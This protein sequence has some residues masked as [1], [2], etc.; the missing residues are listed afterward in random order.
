MSEARDVTAGQI[1]LSLGAAVSEPAPDNGARDGRFLA[2][3]PRVRLQ[4]WQ[5]RLAGHFGRLAGTR[6]DS[7]WPVF[8][9]E[10][11]LH[12]SDRDTLMRDVREC[13]VIGPTRDVPLPWIVYAVEIGYDYSGFEYWQTFESKTPGWQQEWRG[14]IRSRFTAF[15]ATYHGAEPHGDWADQFNIIAWPITHGI[16]PRDLQ[17]QLAEL[18]YDASMSFRAETFSSAE[19]LGRHLQARCLGYSSR[20]RQFAEN[21]ILV[22]QI[23]LALLLQDSGDTLGG[24]AV[25]HTDTLARI[26][27]DLNRERDARQWL[28]DARSAARFRVRGLSSIPLRGRT[29][30]STPHGGR[31]PSIAEDAEALPRPRLL[32]RE[33]S[34]NKWQVRL[35]FPN[36]AHVAATSPRTRNVLARSQ[37]RVAGATG[38]VLATGRIVRDAAPTVTLAAWPLPDT[39]LLSFDGAPPELNAVLHASFR[40]E[41]RESWLFSIG[42][43]GQAREL[44]T[45]VLRAGASY[46][47][48]QTAETRNPPAGLGLRAVQVACAGIYGLRIDVP[49]DV[50]DVLV[51]LLSSVLR[52]EVAQTLDVWPAGL[53]IPDWSGDGNA[54]WVAGHPVILGVRSD[55][56]LT[57]LTFTVDGTGKPDV[58]CATDTSPGTPMF[59]QLPALQP[60]TYR[61][62]IEA[63]TG[64]DDTG[65]S[66]SISGSVRARPGL[67][68]ELLC[69]VR[70]PRSATAGQGGA[71]SF[72]VLPESPSL[73]DVWEDRIEIHVAAP[74]ATSIKGCVVLRAAGGQ[75]A[76]WSLSLPSPCDSDAWRRQFAAVRKAAESKYDDAQTCVLELDAGSLGRG[77]VT[78]ERDFT[79]LRWAIRGNGHRAVLIDSQGCADLAICLVPCAAPSLEQR[80][81]PTAALDG[82]AISDGG[83][84]IIA[85]S[86]RLE[87]AT[88]VVPPQR[89]NSLAALSGVRPNVPTPAREASALA[90]LARKAALWE[91]ARLAG[92]SLAEVRRVAAVEA[93]AG[94]LASVVG[95]ER[96]AEAEEILRNRG[97]QAVADLMRG[98]ITSRPDER[99]VGVM[100][101]ERV[102]PSAEASTVD[103]ERALV[104]AL[105]P[106]VR[107]PNLDALAAYALRLAASP[108]QARALVDAQRN[109][110]GSSD[111]REQELIDGLLNCPVILRAARYFVVATRALARGRVQ[112]ERGMPWER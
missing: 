52:L 76:R 20:F 60:G 92:S 15:A 90:A 29:N 10:H 94:R 49:T 8:A 5:E 19:A 24:A 55:H 46:L 97:P 4:A 75:E 104:D 106:F 62:V 69:V 53:P 93:L 72:A 86:G 96:W 63:A 66:T 57:S 12:E 9:L 7:G 42:S 95:G 109:I 43:D 83:A 111:A 110:D 40:I 48:L 22:G 31:P 45:R 78:A 18:L 112:G 41:A 101:A 25:L 67:R 32:L 58:V 85:R 108:A 98:L 21:T 13:A 61:I 74:G 2:A 103:A 105:R 65:G 91:R 30:E 39:Q 77:R 17:R 28:A 56:R 81:E 107:T 33:E 71:L 54:V 1:A 27:G 82:V 89:V 51:E 68:G 35:Q 80:V 23:A 88:V 64:D 37:G 34:L 16:L 6:R 11:G 3:D 70:E 84:L 73:E 38:P 79:P 59:V 50:P 36:L 102:V 99:A 100:L 87:V 44:A 26:V 14:R 47:L